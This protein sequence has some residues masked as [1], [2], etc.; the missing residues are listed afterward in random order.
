GIG[1]VYQAEGKNKLALESYVQLRRFN[2]LEKD[3][4]GEADVLNLIGRVYEEEGQKDRAL[5]QFQAALAISLAAEDRVNE[6][7]S[8]YNIAK[9]ERDLGA[10]TDARAQIE[11]GLKTIES[12]RSMVMSQELR[13]SFFATVRQHYELYVEILMRLHHE[14][15]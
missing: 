10:L 1:M 2:H 15:A 8:L 3:L 13:S 11:S 12:L 4:R 7:A 14:H 5:K 9:V 6:A